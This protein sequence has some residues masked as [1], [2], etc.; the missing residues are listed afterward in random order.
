MN[1]NTLVRETVQH[2]S[3]HIVEN[4]EQFLATFVSATNAIDCAIYMRNSILFQNTC[5]NLPK[6]EIKIGLSSGLPVS[7]SR[8]SFWGFY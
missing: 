5:L 6:V 3:G 4:H 7:E 2:Y 8:N 1:F